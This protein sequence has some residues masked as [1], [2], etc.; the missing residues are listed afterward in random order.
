MLFTDYKPVIL[1]PKDQREVKRF[2][3]TSSN[4]EI[5]SVL[6]TVL[7]HPELSFIFTHCGTSF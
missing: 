4:V 7:K 6:V 1:F 3:T 2:H 5:T